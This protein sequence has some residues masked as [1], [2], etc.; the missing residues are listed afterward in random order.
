MLPSAS[1]ESQSGA[2]VPTVLVLFVTIPLAELFL[3]IEVGSWI[4]A[5]PTI[6]LCLLT[7]M[8]GAALLRQ[9]GLQTLAR[10]RNNLDRGSLPAVELLEGAALIIGG[11]LL[12]T[13]GLVTDVIGFLCLIPPTRRWLVRLALARM[14]VR[15]G[16]AGPPPGSGSGSAGGSDDRHIIE[17]EYERRDDDPRR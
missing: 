15:V 4:G 17:G 16:P 7:A 11:A 10:A 14:A 1:K 12:L 5:L 2:T 9:Q 8:M 3:L 13:P 6:G